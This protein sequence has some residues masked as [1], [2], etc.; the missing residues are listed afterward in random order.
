MGEKGGLHELECGVLSWNTRL[1]VALSSTCF[2]HSCMELSMPVCLTVCSCTSECTRLSVSLCL[3]VMSE[4][5]Q[6]N[7]ERIRKIDLH[8]SVWRPACVLSRA[9]VD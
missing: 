1:S 5:S 4:G 3:C 6:A 2:G 7:P 9:V 8:V